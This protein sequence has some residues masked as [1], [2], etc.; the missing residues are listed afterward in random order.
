MLGLIL[1]PIDKPAVHE[2]FVVVSIFC[3]TTG[4]LAC[5]AFVWFSVVLF[6]VALYDDHICSPSSFLA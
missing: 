1:T 3:F 4:S 6:A 5:A 2:M